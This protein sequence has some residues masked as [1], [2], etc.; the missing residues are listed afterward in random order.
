[1]TDSDQAPAAILGTST[2]GRNSGAP[3]I[4]LAFSGLELFFVR[5]SAA[6]I[7]ALSWAGQRGEGDA[8]YGALD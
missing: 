5:R 3:D 6:V 7:G 8:R 4:P 2:A 1:M